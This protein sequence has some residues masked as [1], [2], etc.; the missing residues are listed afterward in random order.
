MTYDI[1]NPDPGLWQAQKCG[2]IKPVNGIPT[3]QL[4]YTG[5][6]LEDH[7]F[8]YQKRQSWSTEPW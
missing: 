5:N 7:I 6:T 2:A 3:H 1:G 8:I 4:I